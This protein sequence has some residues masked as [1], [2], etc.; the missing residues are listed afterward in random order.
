[1]TD[2]DVLR[3]TFGQLAVDSGYFVLMT[4]FGLVVST[5]AV[6]RRAGWV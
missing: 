3:A 1:M 5:L 6:F 2:L 4:A